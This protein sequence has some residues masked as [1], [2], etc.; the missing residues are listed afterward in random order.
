MIDDIKTKER[1]GY[2]S[3]DL[4]PKSGKRIVAICDDCGKERLVKKS[5]YRDLCMHCV[6]K[7][8]YRTEK[9]RQERSLRVMGNK[10]PFYGKTHSNETKLK[11][12]KSQQERELRLLGGQSAKN[13]VIRRYVSIDSSLP[14]VLSRITP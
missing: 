10:N 4:K 2:T 14:P 1:F 13:K 5:A 7:F 9:C 12:S 6:Q 3:N 8:C 11:I